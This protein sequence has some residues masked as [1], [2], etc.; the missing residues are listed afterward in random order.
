M[1]RKRVLSHLLLIEGGI[2]ALFVL[3]FFLIFKNYQQLEKDN[4]HTDLIRVHAAIQRDIDLLGH[5]NLQWAGTGG[6]YFAMYND[7]PGTLM[8]RSIVLNSIVGSFNISYAAMFGKDKNFIAAREVNPESFSDFPIEENHAVIESI[9]QAGLIS[10]SDEPRTGF[11]VIEN[12]LFL[13][14]ANPILNPLMD[15][16]V[17]GTMV[18]VRRYGFDAVNSLSE[19]TKQ[20]VSL[21]PT[22]TL[23]NGGP[24]QTHFQRLFYNNKKNYFSPI[25]DST[26]GTFELLQDINN[27]PSVGLAIKTPRNIIM[28]ARQTVIGI[29][30]ALLLVILFRV[31]YTLLFLDRSILLRL[32]GISGDVENLK[33]EENINQRLQVSG[34]DEFTQLAGSFNGLLHA[35]EKSQIL[36]QNERDK[37]KI[38]LD[39]IGDAVISTDLNCNITY[40]NNAALGFFPGQVKHYLGKPIRTLFSPTD[41]NGEESELHIAQQCIDTKEFIHESNYCYLDIQ[42]EEDIII[43]SVACPIIERKEN[44]ASDI[45]GAVIVFRDVSHE[46]RLQQN[47]V[48]QA[49]HDGLTKLFNRSEFERQLK[50]VAKSAHKNNQNHHLIFID[51]DRFKIVNDSCGHMAGDKVLKEIGQLMLSQIRKTDVLARIGGDE[52]AIILMDCKFSRAYDVAEKVRESIANFRFAFQDQS[53]SFGASIGFVNLKDQVF[54]DDADLLSMADKACMA[55]KNSGRNRIHIYRSEDSQLAEQQEYTKWVNRVTDAL[56]NDSFILYYQKIAT[57]KTGNQGQS[58]AEILIRMVDAG[59]ETIPP[60]AFLPA[61]ERYGLMKFIDKWVIEN[62]CVW[63]KDNITIFDEVSVF[64]INLSGQSLSDSEFLNYLVNYFATPIIEPK[65]ICF[66]ITETSAIQNISSA[67]KFITR[68]K[69]MGFSFALDDF[70]SGMSS[71]SY[72]K[73][74]TVDLLKIDGGFVKNI[75]KEAIDHSM[76]RSINDIGHVMGIKTV[77][78]FV[79]NQSICDMLET[80]GVD[81]LQGYHIHKPQPLSQLAVNLKRT[82][83]S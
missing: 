5:Y 4:L 33:A 32:R 73:H 65:H 16:S 74:L 2:F 10:N 34:N 43:Q 56:E 51:L 11:I 83:A 38:T 20:S 8:Y 50:I 78:E 63:A 14:S 57:S 23:I 36:L 62:F 70:G 40:M 28:Q 82:N 49:S 46:K 17:R 52:F 7:E 81:Y 12:E 26:M 37:A 45:T 61:A 44:D 55:A 30:A 59:G 79:E 71:F 53:F 42:K 77:A 9:Q 25:D 64:S 76:V 66:E 1:L 67:R 24:F 58:H 69:A 21:E 29:G 68:L 13:V 27:S 60:G 6:A 41:E 80:I 48:Y 31:F 22:N 54:E 39:S 72:L 18:V 75:E 19:L 47:L 15:K 3:G 35:L